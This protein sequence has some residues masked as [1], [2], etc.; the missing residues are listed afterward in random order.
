MNQTTGSQN[1]WLPQQNI[2]NFAK[3]VWDSHTE[4]GCA[5][6]KCGSNM[7]AVCHYSPAAARYGNPIYTM[8]GPYCN[9]CTRLSARCSQNGL[10]VKNP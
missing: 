2:P 3:M 1:I 8:G 6:V 5:I 10:C 7:K 9:L 4:I